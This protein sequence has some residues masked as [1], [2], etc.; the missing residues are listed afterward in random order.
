MVKVSGDLDIGT[1]PDLR[2]ALFVA[3]SVYEETVVDLARLGFCDCAGLGGLVAVRNA[4]HRRGARLEWQHIPGHLRV[5]LRATRTSLTGTTPAAAGER[6]N[7]CRRALPTPVAASR[8]PES[9]P[10]LGVR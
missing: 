3:V 5:L 6:W 10:P 9:L 4:A 1:V 8:R 2:Q 7:P